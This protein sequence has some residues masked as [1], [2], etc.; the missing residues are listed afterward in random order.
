MS[1]P[2]IYEEAARRMEPAIRKLGTA[3]PDYQ[4]RLRDIANEIKREL[5]MERR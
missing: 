4:D 2:E 1:I 5:A 3:H